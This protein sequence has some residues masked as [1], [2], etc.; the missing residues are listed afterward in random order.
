MKREL[1]ASDIAALAPSEKV[2]LVGTIDPDGEPRL[3]ILTTIMATGARG[4]TVGEFSRGQ[5]KRNM[6]ARPKVGFLV[7]GLDRRLWRG[8][9]AWTRSR[10][11]GPEYEAYN[12][13][14]MF[15]YNTYFGINTV[16]YLDLV[17]A[18]GPAPLPMG[19]IILASLATIA[20]ARGSRAHRPVGASGP[21]G[22]PSG[23]AGGDVMPPSAI[24]IL[25]RLASL[26]FLCAIDAEGYPRVVPVIQARS[27]GRSR[28]VFTPGPWRDELLALPEGARTA[29]LTMNLGMESFLS[30]G[31]LRRLDGLR[32]GRGLLGVDLDWLYNSAPPIHGQVYPPLPLTAKVLT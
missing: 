29:I 22:G 18:E 32:P 27:A 3:S 17:D 1:D 20:K 21:A 6:A 30:R 10:R 23:P 2:G 14:P 26:S 31:S 5:S 9:A 28:I 15:R 13:Q 11:E 12:R 7:M 16:H 4:L 8:R 19:G 24:A 25:D